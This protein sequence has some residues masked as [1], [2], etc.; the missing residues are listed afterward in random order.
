MNSY[1]G[2]TAE[3]RNAAQRWLVQRWNSGTL[4][5]PKECC[6]CG[7]TKGIIHQHAEDYSQPFGE[8]LTKY[9]LC[10][11]CHMALHMRFRL[12]RGWEYYL[13]TLRT[14]WTWKPIFKPSFGLVSS[15]M[16][17][18]PTLRGKPSGPPRPVLVFDTM[19]DDAPKRAPVSKNHELNLK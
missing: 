17:R 7:Q 14:G 15:M 3:Q 8:N 9:P 5:R 13:A 18:R 2:F 12:P 11:R 6:A 1:N 16:N 4:P 10:Y 19:F